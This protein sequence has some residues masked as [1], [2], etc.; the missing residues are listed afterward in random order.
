MWFIRIWENHL[1]NVTPLNDP[2]GGKNLNRVF[3]FEEMTLENIRKIAT[4]WPQ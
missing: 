3:S 2:L 4:G 1:A